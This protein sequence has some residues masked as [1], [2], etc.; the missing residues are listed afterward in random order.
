M[1]VKR[2][3]GQ[4]NQLRAGISFLTELISKKTLKG[5]K[6]KRIITKFNLPRDNFGN[7]IEI[8]KQK[9]QLKVKR[10]TRYKKQ[11]AFYR[12]NTF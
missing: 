2:H 8:M 9:L 11:T 12:R 7:L 5:N 1:S 6:L 3:N 10:Q 4:M